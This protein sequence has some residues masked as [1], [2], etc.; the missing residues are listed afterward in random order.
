MKRLLFLLV[1]MTACMAA[2]AAEGYAV[3]TQS[4]HT[5]TFYYGT[6]PSGAFGL[7]SG[8]NY[9]EWYNY[10]TYAAV[11][12]V[13][14]DPSFAQARPTTTAYWFYEMENLTTIT[15]LNYL[16]TSE[17]TNMLGMFW[18]CKYLTSL[19]LSSFNTANVTDMRFMFNKCEN[20]TS[21]DVSSFN[22]ANVINM[23]AMFW[24]CKNLTSLDVS[25]FNTSN[26]TDMSAMFENCGKLTS[27]DVSSFNTANVTDMRF[28]FNKCE[29]LTSLDL[30]SFNTANVTNMKNMFENCDEL[31][32]ITVGST[33]STEA[34]TSSTDMFTNCFKIEGGAGTTFSS[35]YTDA[36]YAHIDGG[37][38]NPGYLTGATYDLWINGV[39]VTCANQNGVTGPGISGSV[40][41]APSTNTLTLNNATVDR[42]GLSVCAIENAYGGPTNLKIKLVGDNKILA[43]TNNIAINAKESQ[44]FTL[45]GSG[46]LDCGGA[47]YLDA[48]DHLTDH[49]AVSYIKDCSVYFDNILSEGYEECLTIDNADVTTEYLSVGSDHNGY[50]GLNLVNCYVASPANGVVSNYGYI[51]VNG[52]E[53]QG[54]V[55][56]KRS[57]IAGDVNGD[58]HVSSVDVT[59]LYNYLLNNDSS[60]IV[61]GDQDGDGHISSVDVTVVYNILLGN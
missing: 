39:Q 59:A 52:V 46:T 48:H 45:Y 32:T 28:M 24:D 60:D 26:V 41:Y 20:L 47:L 10:G 54:H 37:P 57:A 7:N 22:T 3:Y 56:I 42:R 31:K 40:T 55:E 14:F 50:K 25:S 18:G 2:W 51:T 8:I 19:D 16:N 38:S 33:W 11:E 27:L 44:G 1:T 21:L 29:N 49:A 30:S 35:S 9:P 36:S 34:V 15:G 17:V 12:R 4:N 23:L 5:L 53:W 6:K 58:G 13:V 61:N 43:N